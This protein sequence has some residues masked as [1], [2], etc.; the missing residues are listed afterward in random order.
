VF[1]ILRVLASMGWMYS[2]AVASGDQNQSN[3]VASADFKRRAT[4]AANSAAGSF[5]ID[6]FYFATRNPREVVALASLIA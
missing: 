6:D 1:T 4:L 5:L 3:R 2:C